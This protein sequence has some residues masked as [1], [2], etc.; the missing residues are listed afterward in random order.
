MA[1]SGPG[2]SEREG[3]SIKEL[4][5]MFPDD[6]TA[7]QWFISKRWPDGVRCAFCKSD[8]VQHGAKHPTMPFRCRTCRKFFSAKSNSIMHSSKL[9]YQD[10][11]IGVYSML[12]GI[13]GTS[14]MKLRRDL[15]IGQ[16]AAW[17]MMHKLRETWVE[18][19]PVEEKFRWDRFDGPTEVDETY[20]GGKEGNKHANKK[21]NAGRG[22]V[23]KTA[24]VGIRDRATNRVHIQ[25]VADTTKQTLQ[26]FVTEW[27]GDD[28]VV[29]TDEARAYVGL[30]REHHTIAHGKGEYVRY[31]VHMSNVGEFIEHQI[32]TNGMESFW[33]LFKRGYVGVYHKMSP[34]HLHRYMAEFE[35]RHNDR[36]LDT[37]EQMEAMVEGMDGRRLRYIDL[38]PNSK[39]TRR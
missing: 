4:F 19:A 27:T 38:M 14:S 17:A 3:I 32:S 7:E 1:K 5:K 21:L 25:V 29:Y 11:A 24:V 39:Y 30:P 13:K 23:G 28:T 37:M 12:T 16:E 22:A 2:R 20:V 31:E 10:W 15:G 18:N 35:G 33:S 36:P 9:S 34:E 26:D 8:N 6:E